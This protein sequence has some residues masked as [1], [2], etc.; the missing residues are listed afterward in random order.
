MQLVDKRIIVTGGAQG[1]GEAIVRAYVEEGGR[2]ASLDVKDAEAAKIVEELNAEGAGSCT[3]AHCD[4]SSRDEVEAA[5]RSAVDFLGGLDVLVHAAAINLKGHA[6]DLTESA[7]DAIFDINA[8]G[9]LFTNQAA[10]RYLREHGGTIL[11]FASGAGVRG[12]PNA[13]HYAA[14]KGAV[15]A[16]VRTVA[17]EWGKHNIRVNAICPGMWTPMYQATRDQLSAEEL[18][19]HDAGMAASTALGRRQGDPSTDLAPFMV[20]MAS[21]GANYITGQTMVVDGGRTMA[22]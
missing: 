12:L 13:A 18:V 22:R 5:F 3:Y 7:W 9:T 2:V 10:F 14:S 6:E 1:I 17:F 11:D 19:A 16:W 20:F 4:V 8:K 21:D 15:L